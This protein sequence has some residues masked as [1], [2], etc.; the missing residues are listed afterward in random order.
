M[1][2]KLY[3]L[4]AIYDVAFSWDISR[5]TQFFIG[6]FARYVP[7]E[8][9]RIL[10]P[11]CGSGRFLTEFPRHGYQ[12]TG[13]D[14]SLAMA[15]HARD[16]ISA[17]GC[18]RNARALVADMAS[19]AFDRRLG[20]AF[21][22]INSIG[23]LLT[24]EDVISHL[25]STSAALERGGIYIVHLSFAHDSKPPAG[26]AWA[27]ERDGISVATRWSIESEDRERRLSHQICRMQIDDCGTCTVIEERHVLRLWFF[28]DLM[29]LIRDAGEIRLEAIYD[30]NYRELPTS[31]RVSGELGNLYVVL[32][33]L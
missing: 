33:A 32:R 18:Q 6:L 24:D 7:F 17:A 27:M 14:S 31:T 10:E 29:R 4:P 8:V 30:D 21:N 23:Y 1:P 25:A 20:A 12:I 28:D 16:K 3:N 22:S 2:E 26:D 15:A 5:E 9:T 11:A 13:Y 19:A